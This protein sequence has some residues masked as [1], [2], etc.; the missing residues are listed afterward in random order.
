MFC[1][2]ETPKNHTLWEVRDERECSPERGRMQLT[3]ANYNWLSNDDLAET[4][5]VE[6]WTTEKVMKGMFHNQ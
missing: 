5:H 3:A 6:N 4:C 2:S 1:D